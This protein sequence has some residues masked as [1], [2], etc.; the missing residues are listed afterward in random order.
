[1][2]LAELESTAAAA[3]GRTVIEMD[4]VDKDFVLGGTFFNQTVLRALSGVSLKLVSGRALALVGYED[5]DD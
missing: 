4:S 3:T 5:E 2:S 1:M